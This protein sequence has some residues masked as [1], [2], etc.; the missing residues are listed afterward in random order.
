MVKASWCFIS[1]WTRMMKQKWECFLLRVQFP[2]LLSSHLGNKVIGQ[3]WARDSQRDAAEQ[4]NVAPSSNEKFKASSAD[5][6]PCPRA[7]YGSRDCLKASWLTS[8]TR[9]MVSTF[10]WESRCQVKISLTCFVHL[11]HVPKDSERWENNMGLINDRKKVSDLQRLPLFF[12]FLASAELWQSPLPPFP[13]S[14]LVLC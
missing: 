3:M 7:I 10:F 14:T 11:T 5:C 1:L 12:L 2:Q 9:W 8:G 6:E 13:S 4:S